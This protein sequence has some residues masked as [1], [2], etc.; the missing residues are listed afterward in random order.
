LKLHKVFPQIVPFVRS[1]GK[2]RQIQAG[3]RRQY[4]VAH[5]QYMPDN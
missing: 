4:K 2:L 3:H 5:A 1:C